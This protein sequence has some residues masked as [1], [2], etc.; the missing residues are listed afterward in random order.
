MST[1]IAI[2]PYLGDFQEGQTVYIY[3][4]TYGASGESITLTG[5]AAADIEIYK[6]G[7]MTQ[8]A[9]DSGYTLLATGGI[10]LDSVTGIHGV[11]I[12]LSDDTDSGFFA[13]GH[14]YMVVINSVTVNSQTVNIPVASFSI[15]NRFNSA[16]VGDY[17]V[18]LTIRTTGGVAVSGVSV[19]VNSSN[20]RTGS[21]AGSKVTSA[22]GQVSFNLAYGTYYVF[23]SLSGYT[24]AAASFT[25]AAGSVSFTKDIATATA[26][27]SSSYYTD[28]F[29]TRGITDVREALDEPAISA[30]YTDARIIEHLEKAYILVL[31]EKNRQDKTP[32]VVKQDLTIAANTTTYILPYTMGSFLGLYS[33]GDSGGK[34]YYDG[35]SRFNPYGQRVWLEGQTLHIQST[36]LFGIGTALKME[37]IPSG[38]ARLHNGT[39]TISADGKTVTLGATPNSGTLDTHDNAYSG[40]V[41]RILGASGTTV[42]GNYLQERNIT[43]YDN[44]TRAA[45][46]DVA[47]DPI[48]TTDDGYIY[49]EI[50]PAIHKGMDMVVALYAA[51]RIM[52]VEGNQKRA[53]GILA[54]YRNE[55]R[56]VR[57]STYYS[58]MPEAPRLRGDSFDNTR[59]RG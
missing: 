37:W 11:S 42:V 36:D 18:T 39:C 40:G 2:A 26:T 8:R 46:L 10:D 6:D 16:G 35:N 15:Q 52:T 32:A 30:K 9:S 56:N 13:K 43:A 34:V 31:N 24:F 1:P 48:P 20:D 14:D 59:Y 28:S 23:C 38:I 54:A 17:A 49:Y 27:G 3:W 29:L 12:D 21:V 51:Y 47:L 44:T 7:S 58:N 33:E 25:A 22:S 5:L 55:I 50:A 4:G 45:T 41:L 19:W 53:N 57:L